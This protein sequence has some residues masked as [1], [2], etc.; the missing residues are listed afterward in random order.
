MGA[1]AER[2]HRTTGQGMKRNIMSGKIL[3]LKNYKLIDKVTTGA[4]IK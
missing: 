4:W 2:G 3:K 1:E